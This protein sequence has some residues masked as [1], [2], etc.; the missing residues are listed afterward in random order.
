M[1]RWLADGNLEYLGRI[2][3]QVKIRGYRIELGEIQSVVQQSGY[4]NQSV[5]IAREDIQGSRRLI[6]YVVSNGSFHRD[7]LVRYLQKHLPDYMVPQL[8]VELESIPLT[9][10]GK[11]DK[12][13][14]PHVDASELQPGE[15]VA[16]RNAVEQMLCKIWGEVLGV[17]RVGVHD[18]FFA[19]GGDSIITIQITSRAKRA[20]YELRPRDIFVH[21]SISRLSLYLSSSVSGSSIAEQGELEGESG[22][23]PIQQWYFEREGFNS[24]ISHYNQSVLL[25]IDRGVSVSELRKVFS[26]IEHHHDALRYEYSRS[27]SGVW[28]Q[29]YGVKRL[30][31]TECDLSDIDSGDL[32]SELSFRSDSYQSSLC[33]DGGDLFR[34]V[35]FRTPSGENL[36]RLLIVIH[37]LAVDGVSWRILLE[38]LELLLGCLRSGSS[39]SL[40]SK[41]SS[42]R[43]WYNSLKEYSSHPRLLSQQSYWDT[44]QD[45]GSPLPVDHGDSVRSLY[46]AWD[47][48]SVTLPALPTRLLLQEVSGAYHTEINDILLAALS[49][50][51]SEWS[52][53]DNVLI[54]LEGHGREEQVCEGIDLSRT[55]GWFT[56]LYPVLLEYQAS[57][58]PGD[59]VKGTK[60]GLRRLPDKGLGYGVLK[61]ILGSSQLSE[62]RWDITFNYLGQFDNLTSRSS[63]FSRSEEPRGR[64]SSSSHRSSENL[65]VNSMI[66]G[67]E[68]SLWWHYS[69]SHYNRS[70]IEALSSRY[71]SVLEE[72]ITHCVNQSKTSPVYTP[73]DYGLEKEISY[74]QLDDFLDSYNSDKDI[75]EF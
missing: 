59:L 62:D 7:D 66:S 23:L 70:T 26:V 55:I 12:G 44:L 57:A 43:D 72:L 68:L 30:D 17:D 51:L 14:L 18:N 1:G 6:G 75:M 41:S 21:Q 49:R 50:T 9:R 24:S 73:S 48:V 20:G 5:V 35:L 64:E 2:D 8:W 29:R 65:A 11:V 31:L 38:D 53:H 69:C 45:K 74:K 47:V 27:S 58:D 67:G 54:G 52:G 10:N 28:E 33:I 60:E 34:V 36:N 15:Y 16:P 61:Y 42:Y 71:L 40:G 22:L 46:S 4:V 19:L 37:H 56:S 32:S 39:L 25:G 63:F 3:D 13:A